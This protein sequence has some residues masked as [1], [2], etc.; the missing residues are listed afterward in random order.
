ME[1]IKNLK[2]E[3]KG[4]I[5]IYLNDGR[6]IIVPLSFFPPIKKL[7]PTQRKKWQIL[8]GVGFTFEDTDELFHLSQVLG[9][10]NPP[11]C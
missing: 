1:R 4:K 8:D 10:V 5:T 2:F 9:H 11:C 3:K 7:S 6:V